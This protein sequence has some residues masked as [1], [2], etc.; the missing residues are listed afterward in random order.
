[1]L[2][3]SAILRDTPMLVLLT[4]EPTGK[5][6]ENN[7][8][9]RRTV[10]RILLIMRPKSI[11]IEILTSKTCLVK[12]VMRLLTRQDNNSLTMALPPMQMSKKKVGTC[13]GIVVSMTQS[14]PRMSLNVGVMA[15]STW[16]LSTIN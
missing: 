6:L 1:M 7:K 11:L 3:Q 5:A 15:S 12:Q 13:H 2:I 4:L 8:G 10:P 14:H 16:A 9:A